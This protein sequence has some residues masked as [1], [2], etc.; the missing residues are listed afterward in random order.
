[1]DRFS[2]QRPPS[3]TPFLLAAPP[4]VAALLSFAVMAAPD[5]VAAQ[6][7]THRAA[8]EPKDGDPDGERSIDVVTVDPALF[9]AGGLLSLEYERAI[10]PSF[11]LFLGFQALVLNPFGFWSDDLGFFGGTVGSRFYFGGEAPFGW[12]I[13]PMAHVSS[14][15]IR[16]DEV[17]GW[18]LGIF[19]GYSFDFDPAILSIG[20]GAIYVDY[21]TFEEAMP[22]GRI[23]LGIAF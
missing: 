2:G 10:S 22:W 1:M 8:Q 12:S 14:V 9:I 11:S 5:A 18:V 7:P 21:G 16:N 23:A 17:V 6:E 13:G 3:A 20:V 4:I 19:G 15:R